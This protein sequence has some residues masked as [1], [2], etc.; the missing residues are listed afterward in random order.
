[1]CELL[2]V[3]LD[4]P[5]VLD[6]GLWTGEGELDEQRFEG[7]AVPRPALHLAEQPIDDRRG[8]AGGGLAVMI[9]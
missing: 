8:V 2:L 9:E 6:H 3:A 5:Q 4:R 7:R 1:M